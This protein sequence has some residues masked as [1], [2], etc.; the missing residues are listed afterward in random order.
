M[1]DNNITELEERRE[2]LKKN[3]EETEKIGRIT[4]EELAKEQREQKEQNKVTFDWFKQ[5]LSMTLK[6]VSQNQAQNS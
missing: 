2:E 4:M 5:E 3:R 1:A 6:E